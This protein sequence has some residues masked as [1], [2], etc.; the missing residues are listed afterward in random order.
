MIYLASKYLILYIVATLSSMVMLAI[1]F[2]SAFGFE[3]DR[4]TVFA[5]DCVVNVMCLHLQYSFNAPCFDRYCFVL[6]ICCQRIL[7]R[8]VRSYV[9]QASRSRMSLTVSIPTHSVAK[10]VSIQSM[11]STHSKT[12]SVV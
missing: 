2:L 11:Q 8:N 4:G 6:D 3:M 5:V 12:M 1:A 10:S 9:K 7:T